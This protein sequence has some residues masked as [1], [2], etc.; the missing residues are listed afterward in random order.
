MR[1]V[2]YGTPGAVRD[3]LTCVAILVG[4]GAL[5]F[6]AGMISW[7]YSIRDAQAKA[8]GIGLASKPACSM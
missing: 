8:L 3:F 6:V 4:F 5:L 7:S 1:I 2:A